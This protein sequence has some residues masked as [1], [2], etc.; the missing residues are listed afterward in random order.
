MEFGE[1][2]KLERE[3]LGI[4][5]GAL[6]LHLKLS[7]GYMSGVELNRSAPPREEIIRRWAA[8]LKIDPDEAVILA[9]RRFPEGNVRRTA[10]ERLAE[11]VQLRGRANV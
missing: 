9:S 6:A 2:M 10:G 7:P 8:A 1:R 4:K 11:L 5:Q 3:R